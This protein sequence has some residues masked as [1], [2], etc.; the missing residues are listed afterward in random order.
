MLFF[1]VSRRE[2]GSSA[3]LDRD[4][5]KR[6]PLILK[7]PALWARATSSVGETP[8]TR[9]PRDGLV[10]KAC[11]HR[12]IGQAGSDMTNKL[13]HL[14][15]SQMH[16]VAVRTDANESGEQPGKMERAPPRY[17]RAWRLR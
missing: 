16:D 17:L 13:D 5:G 2:R 4:L 14:L 15:P 6:E 3:P 9:R 12:D 7:I 10:G 11:A 1:L 8:W